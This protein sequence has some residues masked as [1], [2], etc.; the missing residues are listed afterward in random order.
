MK[1]KL[2]LSEN[3]LVIIQ[4]ALEG[5]SRAGTEQYDI[6]I[7]KAINVAIKNIT[8]SELGENSSHG[9]HSQNISDNYRVAYDMIQVL[10]NKR[11]WA[12]V[13]DAENSKENHGSKYMGV[14]YST[15]YKTSTEDEPLIKCEASDD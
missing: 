2:E 3:Q 11:A 5:Y 8:G 1:Y 12:N 6:I 14:S 10:R 7:N 4:N 9:I 15:P 13:E